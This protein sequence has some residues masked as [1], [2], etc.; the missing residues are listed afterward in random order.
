MPPI[1][2]S[3]LGASAAERWMNCPPSAR[4]T[5]EMADNLGLA[6]LD[7]AV[8]ILLVKAGQYAANALLGAVAAESQVRG[9]KITHLK[10]F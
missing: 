1:T 2:H 10:T 8:N 5:A 7:K 9:G 6:V 4:L 3:I